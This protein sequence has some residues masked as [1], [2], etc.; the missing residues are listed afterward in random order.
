LSRERSE[1]AR[2]AAVRTESR[3]TLRAGPDPARIF[4][5]GFG[6][7]TST[8][9]DTLIL[10]PYLATV[11]KATRTREIETRT[12]APPINARNDSG[13]KVKLQ[14]DGANQSDPTIGCVECQ[15]NHSLEEYPVR[16]HEAMRTTARV[17]SHKVRIVLPSGHR[18][19]KKQVAA[20][21]A[22]ERHGSSLALTSRRPLR[23]TCACTPVA[24]RH[25]HP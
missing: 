13:A 11:T 4:C 19:T 3:P 25:T 7:S 2:K 1:A 14:I 23:P 18:R 17:A 15:R 21:V 12:A 8:I 9:T 16:E 5:G 24:P 22:A 20:V 10:V 6:G